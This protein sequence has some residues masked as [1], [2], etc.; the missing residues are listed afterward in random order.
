MPAKWV[1]YLL[2]DA[3]DQPVQLLCVKNLRTSLKR[4][5]G[6]ERAGRRAE[7]ARGLPRAGPA[8]LLAAGRQRV[9]GG[10]VYLEA[11]RA[12]FPQSYRGMLGFP[13]RRGLCTSNPATNFPR[14]V[15]TIDISGQRWVTDR[16]GGRQARGGAVDPAH[17]RCVRLVPLLHRADGSAGAGGRARTRR[18]ASARRRATDRSRCGQY[19][20]MMRW[21]IETAVSPDELIEQTRSGWPRRRAI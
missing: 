3:D 20:E 12:V 18:W 14:L 8:G 15:K 1:V 6:P 13:S 16:P 10:L 9:R 17:R 7:P 2:A 4:R 5:L 19:P 21:G 11:A